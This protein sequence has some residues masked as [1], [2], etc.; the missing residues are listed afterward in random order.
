MYLINPLERKKERKKRL[1]RNAVGSFCTFLFSAALWQTSSRR[2]RCFRTT[3]TRGRCWRRWF[4]AHWL[5]AFPCRSFH[6]Q[7]SGLLEVASLAVPLQTDNENYRH[8]PYLCKQTDNDNYRHWPYL[9]KQTTRIIVTGRT[10][11]NRQTTII[12]V[13]GRT[14]ANR[15]R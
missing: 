9:C 15:Q 11:A 14:S 3:W 1:E 6:S 5:G 2:R 13:T 10:F 4:C 7:V 12:I 8:W